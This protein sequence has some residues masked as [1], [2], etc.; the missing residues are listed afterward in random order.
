MHTQSSSSSPN[1]PQDE[2]GFRGAA[3]TTKLAAM[4]AHATI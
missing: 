2:N 3:D 4:A 1:L